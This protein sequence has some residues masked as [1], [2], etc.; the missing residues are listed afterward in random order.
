MSTETGKIHN[1]YVT[2][3]GNHTIRK[4]VIASGAATTLAGTPGSAGSAD[5][6]GSA[7]R[8]HSE[9]DIATDGT[10]VHVVDSFN[11]TIRKIAIATGAVTT[12]T[13][14][15]GSSGSIDGAR[16]VA[17]FNYPYDV[18]TDGTNLYV[19]HGNSSASQ[20]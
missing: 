3:Q 4:V 5:G 15:A 13:G 19:V 17:R 9:Y 7:A 1:L 20:G 16:S 2:D 8:F 6:F 10:N 14:T 12:L 18:A 11:H